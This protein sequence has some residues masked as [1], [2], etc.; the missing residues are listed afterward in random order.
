M[1]IFK[2]KYLIFNNKYQNVKIYNYL[3]KTQK[4]N[5]ILIQKL[6]NMIYIIIYIYYKY[7]YI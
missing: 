6:K 2:I 4:N 3:Y 5:I 7:K 1:K